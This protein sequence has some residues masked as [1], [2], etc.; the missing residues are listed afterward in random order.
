MRVDNDEYRG[1]SSFVLV[2]ALV[3]GCCLNMEYI[4]IRDGKIEVISRRAVVP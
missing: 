2:S 1:S 4:E 3:S